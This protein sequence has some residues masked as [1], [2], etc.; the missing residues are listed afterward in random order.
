MKKKILFLVTHS[1]IF[2]GFFNQKLKI[3]QKFMIS[4]FWSLNM[5]SI[6]LNLERNKESGIKI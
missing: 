2:K 5:V 4:I 1:I 6:I 3:F